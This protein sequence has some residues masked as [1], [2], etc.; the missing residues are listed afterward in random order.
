MQSKQIKK[1]PTKKSLSFSTIFPHLE[2]LEYENWKCDCN[3]KIFFS[4]F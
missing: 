2:D 3:S 1:N 4:T